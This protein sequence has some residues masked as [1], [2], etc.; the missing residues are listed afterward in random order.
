MRPAPLPFAS[1]DLMRRTDYRK[2]SAR[3]KPLGGRFDA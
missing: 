1:A 2:S 3:D